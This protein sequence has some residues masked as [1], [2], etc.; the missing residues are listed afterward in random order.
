MLLSLHS[1]FNTA[2]RIFLL[3]WVRSFFWSKYYSSSPMHTEKIWGLYSDPQTSMWPVS[4]LSDLISHY[5][6]LLS[7]NSAHTRWFYVPWTHQA[8]SSMGVW[9]SLGNT[10]FPQMPWTLFCPS[11]LCWT[12]TS[13]II[14]YDI[15]VHNPSLI[16]PEFPHFMLLSSSNP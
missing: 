12:I 9:H 15:S 3:K 14:I 8:Y 6:T 7:L 4:T 5:S 16:M 11:S 13:I 1:I 2:T 10:F